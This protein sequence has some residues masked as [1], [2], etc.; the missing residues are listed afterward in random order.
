MTWK[1]LS[2]KPG[3]MVRV[4]LG[5][6][7]HYGVFVDGGEIIQF[8][9]APTARQMLKDS[10]IE[11]CASDKATFLCGG[12]LETAVLNETEEKTRRNPRE[13]I[14][15]C[16]SRLGERG[17][18]ILYNNCEHFAYECVMGEKK[19]T[20]ADEVRKL[21]RNMPIADVY[22]AKIPKTNGAVSEEKINLL[23]P[24]QRAQEINGCS[25][26]GVKNQK[27]YVWKLLEYALLRSFGYKIHDLQLEKNANGKWTTSACFFSLSHSNGVVAAA[28]SRSE[29]G[30]DIESLSNAKLEILE[31]VLTDEEKSVYQQSIQ[32]ANDYRTQFLMEK[33]TAKESL[34]KA[35]GGARF[36][37]SKIYADEKFVKTVTEEIDGEKYALSVATAHLSKIRYFANIDLTRL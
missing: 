17:Y 26:E 33:W 4:K 30:V 8:G 1:N 5:D 14:A 20:Q 7:Y 15:L 24:L 35:N 22:W 2:P 34:F 37:P 12:V 13:T 6:I 28:V 36:Q 32:D 16:R 23:Y 31:R 18:N 21:F 25:H 11:V 29:I 27:Y 10:E 19:C 3:D 9:L